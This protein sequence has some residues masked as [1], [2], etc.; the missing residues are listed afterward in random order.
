MWSK[1]RAAMMNYR[2]VDLARLF[3][4]CGPIQIT[5]P[6]LKHAPLQIPKITVTAELD[7]K[8]NSKK[9]RF[10]EGLTK[11]AVTS[12]LSSLLRSSRQSPLVVC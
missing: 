7:K 8:S 4:L 10:P 11:I 3:D 2:R 1:W 5:H 12:G 9:L 6:E